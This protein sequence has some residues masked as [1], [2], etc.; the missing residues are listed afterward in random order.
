[1]TYY[2]INYILRFQMKRWGI[3]LAV[4]FTFSANSCAPKKPSNNQYDS[5]RL[6]YKHDKEGNVIFGDKQELINSVRSGS[7]IKVG[8]GGPRISDSTQTLEHL[9]N[10]NFI[11]ILNNQDV[12]V[13]VEQIIGQRPFFTND[14]LKIQF[15]PSNKWTAIIGSNGYMTGLM[16]DYLNDSIVSEGNERKIGVAWFVSNQSS[17]T[18]APLWNIKQ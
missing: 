10:G 15:R 18:Y 14:S 17:R 8:W 9:T 4:F 5:W 6:V 12:F 11:S 2:N 13:Q 1:M 16:T 3:G 7:S